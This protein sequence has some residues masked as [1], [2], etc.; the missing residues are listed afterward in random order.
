MFKRAEKRV[1]KALGFFTK[2]KSEV[3]KANTELDSDLESGYKNMNG[4]QQKIQ[5][6]QAEYEEEL[7]YQRDREI[8]IEDNEEFIEELNKFIPRSSQ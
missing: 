8:A 2:A 7:M 5:K 6:L 1:E 4:I 3:E